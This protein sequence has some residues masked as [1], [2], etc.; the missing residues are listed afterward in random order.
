M[1]R[2][3]VWKSI[4]PTV[5]TFSFEVHNYHGENIWVAIP[6]KFLCEPCMTKRLSR[7]IEWFDLR[8]C[9]MNLTHPAYDA[10]AI[11]L[12]ELEDM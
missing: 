10:L 2:A 11:K 7:S 5:S 3:P 8:Q 1:L 4:E 6:H 9:L 12:S